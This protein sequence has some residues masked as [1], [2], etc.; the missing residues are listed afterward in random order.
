MTR[1]FTSLVFTTVLLGSL[2][3]FAPQ[4]AEAGP[5]G[6]YRAPYVAAYRYPV[7]RAPYVV[8]PR[9]LYRPILPPFAPVVRVAP[10]YPYPY[11]YPVPAP[12]PYP[13]YPY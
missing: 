8:A 5:W 1:V 12:V 9:V 10:V 11:G 13:V 4:R 6:F 3:A 2:A 7:Y